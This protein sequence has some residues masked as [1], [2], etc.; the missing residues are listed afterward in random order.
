MWRRCE[1]WRWWGEGSCARGHTENGSVAAKRTNPVLGFGAWRL[2]TLAPNCFGFVATA[3]LKAQ[4]GRDGNAA[5]RGGGGRE[6]G[7]SLGFVLNRNE[8]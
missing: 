1:V 3:V 5:A 2:W 6:E 4:L 8:I 7:A